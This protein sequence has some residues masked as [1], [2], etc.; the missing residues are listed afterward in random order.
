[1]RAPSNRD[2]SCP[3]GPA[4]DA[5]VPT[6]ATALAAVDDASEAR[7]EDNAAVPR[8]AVSTVSAAMATAVDVTPVAGSATAIAEDGTA[9]LIATACDEACGA[10]ALIDAWIDAPVAPPAAKLTAAIATPFA[11]H[12]DAAAVSAGA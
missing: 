8:G 10:G 9:A 2:R 5:R 4:R 12:P 6:L 7:A 1:M 3:G 11:S